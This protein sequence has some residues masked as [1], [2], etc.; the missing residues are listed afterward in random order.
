MVIVMKVVR[1]L[2]CP[3]LNTWDDYRAIVT[4]Y[5]AT[6]HYQLRTPE[7]SHEQKHWATTHY[8]L[9]THEGSHESRNPPLPAQN[10]RTWSWKR[11][12]PKA[13]I[14]QKT[15]YSSYSSL[16]LS[17]GRVS[18]VMRHSRRWQSIWTWEISTM[19]VTFLKRVRR[20]SSSMGTYFSKR[21]V[22]LAFSETTSRDSIQ[23]WTNL[24]QGI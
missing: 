18:G 3:L 16:V 1:I 15:K 4:K 21:T 11:H 17:G 13:Q 14:Q 24:V 23:L 5:C 2:V 6:T 20:T 10:T 9:R 22:K 12:P 7:G 19:G 8:L